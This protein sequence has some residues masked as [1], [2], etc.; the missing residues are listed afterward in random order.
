MAL[1]VEPVVAQRGSSNGT[2]RA[3]DP[4]ARSWDIR[5]GIQRALYNDSDIGCDHYGILA[6]D[7]WPSG[8]PLHRG[9]IDGAGACDLTISVVGCDNMS[10]LSCA[11]VKDGDKLSNLDVAS[12]A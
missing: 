3:V 7:R 10:R 6:L 9:N 8:P 5:M 12:P 2:G 11:G 4:P 1:G